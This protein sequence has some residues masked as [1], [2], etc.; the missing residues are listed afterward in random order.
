MGAN[1]HRIVARSRLALLQIPL[2]ALCRGAV[3]RHQPGF[4]ELGL[5]DQKPVGGDVSGF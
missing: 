4:P 1:E 3:Q 2:Q 5:P